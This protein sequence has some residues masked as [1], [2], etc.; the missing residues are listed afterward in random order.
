MA[1]SSLVVWSAIM[2]PLQRLR[3]STFVMMVIIWWGMRPGSARVMVVGVEVHPSAFQRKEVCVAVNFTISVS[4][5]A[6]SN[7]ICMLFGSGRCF[8]QLVCAIVN[9]AMFIATSLPV[10]PQHLY[11]LLH[12]NTI[13]G[14]QL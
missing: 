13:A 10:N 14:Q 12:A 11:T 5:P 8:L 1:H 2:E 3:Q 6:W 4:V 7:S 9:A